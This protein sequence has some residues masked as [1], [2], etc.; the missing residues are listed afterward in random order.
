MRL[1][2]N[3]EVHVRVL[4][5]RPRTVFIP[6]PPP[7][8]PPPPRDTIFPEKKCR[9]KSFAKRT[10]YGTFGLFTYS[11]VRSSFCS[12]EITCRIREPRHAER[13]QHKQKG[14]TRE[15]QKL[16]RIIHRLMLQLRIEQIRILIFFSI[17]LHF[18]DRFNIGINYYTIWITTN[19]DK[20]AFIHLDD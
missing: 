10:F 3:C 6:P 19:V 12:P 20:S 2:A 1:L 17:L 8:A 7:P 11:F 13:D 5:K 14:I 9:D 16:N 4:S 15:T 18:T